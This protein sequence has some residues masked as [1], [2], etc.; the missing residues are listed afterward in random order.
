MRDHLSEGFWR[1]RGVPGTQD[2]MQ[3]K[4][5][6]LFFAPICNPYPKTK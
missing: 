1:M 2:P 4:T 5:L 3:N 6:V